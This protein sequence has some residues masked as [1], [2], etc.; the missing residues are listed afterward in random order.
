M[1]QLTDD[2]SAVKCLSTG[3]TIP[4]DA[5]TWQARLYQ[6]WLLAGNVPAATPLA[7]QPYSAEHF[8]AIRASAWAWMTAWV[9]E[10]R[11]DSIESC[12]GYFNSGVDR[13][14]LEAHAMVAW[15]DQVNQ[16]LEQM[17][18]APP[19]GVI[20]WDQVRSLLPQPET[21]SWPG[22]VVLPLSISESA[23]LE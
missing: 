6:D 19:A 18:L 14:R 9:A 4:V 11:Y 8:D 10:R 16:A 13:Y 1:Y 7:Y 12:V 23:V 17:V 20:T 21:F 15:R 5:D 3:A 22:E 2:P